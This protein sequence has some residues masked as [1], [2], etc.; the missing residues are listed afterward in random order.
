MLISP[1]AAQEL[2]YNGDLEIHTQL[3]NGI[4]QWNYCSGWTN[5]GSPTASPDYL[6]LQGSGSVQLPNSVFA[7]IMPYSGSAILGFAAIHNSTI[8]F[9]E[10]LSTQL[11][12]PMQAGQSYTVSFFISNGSSGQY[13]TGAVDHIGV[14]MSVGPLVQTLDLPLGGTP[15]YE[16]P[17]TVW[18]LNWQQYSFTLVAD[19]P[20]THFTIGNFFSDAST[21]VTS[22]GASNNCAYYMVDSI[23]IQPSN[24]YV[25]GNTTICLGESTTLIGTTGESH[26]WALASDP[27]VLISTNDSLVISPDETTSYIYYGPDTLTITVELITPPQVQLGNDTSFCIG[28]SIMLD[29]TQPDVAYLWNDGST[30]A[31][32]SAS[33]AGEYWVEVSNVCGAASDTISIDPIMPPIVDLP[34]DTTLCEGAT[35]QLDVTNAG[36]NYLWNDGSTSADHAVVSQG[37]VSV[38][39]SNACGNVSDSFFVSFETIP[40]VQL[41]NDTAICLNSM[42]VIQLAEVYELVTWQD[43]SGGTSFTITVPGNYSVIVSNV[44]GSNTDSINVSELPPFEIDLGDDLS[45]CPGTE[46]ILYADPAIGTTLWS[47]GVTGA[48]MIV[49]SP[50]TYWAD[51]FHPCGASTDTI[52]ITSAVCEP[53]LEMPNIFTPNSDGSNELFLPIIMENLGNPVL[54]VFN[55]W[56]MPMLDAQTLSAGWNGRHNGEPCP[57]GTYYWIVQYNAADGPRSE[58]GHLTLLR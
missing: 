18:H 22:M 34:D 17:G 33:D 6:H 9:R 30:A 39:V 55:K 32:L 28:G 16:I 27:N 23:S 10:Y 14:T 54:M 37:P 49:D 24:S 50:G 45:I 5:S 40:Q 19:Q 15:H 2:I 11:V 52:S 46:I 41:G 31:T 26:A 48:A 36:S 29:A 3:P 53:M 4:A 57:E 47:N 8:D 1:L 25:T 7:N 35:L 44:C 43:G 21:N 12:A 42:I 38:I 13:C 58:R 20:Y 51:H 56:G